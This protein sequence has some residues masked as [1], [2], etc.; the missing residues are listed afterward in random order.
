MVFKKQKFKGKVPGYSVKTVDTTGAGDSFV[1]AFLVSL[2]KDGSIL[3][4][5]NTPEH[6]QVFD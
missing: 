5:S 1:G 3:D 4:V 2:G 6:F